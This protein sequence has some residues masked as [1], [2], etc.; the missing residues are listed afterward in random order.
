MAKEVPP[1]AIDSPNFVASPRATGDCPVCMFPLSDPETL[2]PCGH[3]FCGSCITTI[4][5]RFA[6]KRRGA[7]TGRGGRNNGGSRSRSTSRPREHRE[8]LA[9]AGRDSPGDYSGSSCAGDRRSDRWSSEDNVLRRLGAQE[10]DE[11][12]ATDE[13]CPLCSRS[14]AS[15]FIQQRWHCRNMVSVAH[16]AVRDKH[17]EA[18]SL[19]SGLKRCI[20]GH[21]AKLF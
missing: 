3:S 13:T 12:T 19:E 15:L 2:E 7:S 18:E 10:A 6:R 20:H 8:Q 1:T 9:L 11:T 21:V 17:I 5:E 16:E 4:R 14:S